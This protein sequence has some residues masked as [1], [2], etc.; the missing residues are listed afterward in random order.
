MPLGRAGPLLVALIACAAAAAIVLLALDDDGPPRAQG[1]AVDPQLAQ[2]QPRQLAGQRLVCGFQGTA[3]PGI[4]RQQIAAGELAGVILF[5]R[6]IRS[7]EQTRALTAELQAIE[8]AAPLDAPLITAVDEEGGSVSRIPGAPRASA[9][10]IG[11]RGPGFARGQGAAVGALM[12]R[13]GLNLDLAPVLD[14]ARKG[15]FIAAQR[16]SFGSRPGRVASVGVAF[17]QGLGDAGV[18]ATAK[19]FPGLGS[20]PDNTDLRPATIRL[21]AGKLR[22]VDEAA[23]D[24][25]A[26]A[27]G[28]LVMV[29][30][31]RYPTLGAGVPA[32]QSKAV[33][34]G[35]LRGRVGFDGVSIT[36][37]LEGKGAQVTGPPRKVAL[38]VARAGMDI[39]LYGSCNT[40]VKAREA[41]GRALR[42]GRLPRAPFE[43]SVARILALRA[44]LAS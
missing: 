35:E 37:A 41:L 24:A 10:E 15:G 6:N 38:R 11:R 25:F 8:R 12:T 21:R 20:T 14:V 5:E 4:V 28:E 40:A 1:P 39:L 34:T 13:A 2:L 17:T 42:S 31:A 7:V 43:Q 16:R 30:S 27:G 9:A 44:G 19:H 36:D 29:S 32:S 3:L 23:Y 26:R 33:A 22:R 18:V